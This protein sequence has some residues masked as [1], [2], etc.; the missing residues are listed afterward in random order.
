M[1]LQSR[2]GAADVKRF[3]PDDDEKEHIKNMP[4]DVAKEI[5]R[6]WHEF[7]C[8]LDNLADDE[9][10]ALGQR[11]HEIM[12]DALKAAEAVRT[13]AVTE[14]HIAQLKKDGKLNPDFVIDPI[15]WPV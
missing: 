9:L 10:K 8:A 13:N 3:D 5:V 1:H 7:A 12:A 2:S 14:G 4:V 11:A 6:M 15:Q